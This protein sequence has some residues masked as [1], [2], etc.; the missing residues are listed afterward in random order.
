MLEDQ[1]QA[2]KWYMTTQYD[3]D[4]SEDDEDDEEED[5]DEAEV[6]GTNGG[7]NGH[8]TT[9]EVRINERLLPKLDVDVSLP[10]PTDLLAHLFP[11]PG[12]EIMGNLVLQQ[13]NLWMGNG[14]S[15]KSS[16]LHHDFHD[17]LY[18]LVSALRILS[19]TSGSNAE[20]ISLSK[21]SGRKRFLIWPPIAHRWLEPVGKVDV[22]HSNG[23]IEYDVPGQ[24]PLLADGLTRVESAKWL[25]R[26][27][28]RAL[29]EADEMAARMTGEQ[30]VE[31]GLRKGKGKQTAEQELAL[32]RLR[33]AEVDLYLLQMEGETGQEESEVL[34]TISSQDT[35]SELSDLFEQDEE[36]TDED[37]DTTDEKM[38]DSDDDLKLDG[39]DD[40]VDEFSS[41]EEDSKRTRRSK[42]GKQSREQESLDEDEYANAQPIKKHRRLSPKLI[43][44]KGHLPGGLR[45][46]LQ[47][48]QGDLDSGSDEYADEDEEGALVYIDASTEEDINGEEAA[49][50]TLQMRSEVVAR[51]RGMAGDTLTEEQSQGILDGQLPASNAVEEDLDSDTGDSWPDLDADALEEG[52]AAL[53]E[54]ARLQDKKEG[55]SRKTTQSKHVDDP[56][57]FSRIEPKVIQWFFNKPFDPQTNQPPMLPPSPE[58]KVYLAPREGCPLPMEIHLKAGQMLYLPASWYHEV[59]SYSDS[60]EESGLHMALN[61]W[62]HPP[63]AIRRPNQP[64]PVQT[65]GGSRAKEARPDSSQPYLNSEVWDEIRRCVNRKV[66]AIRRRAAARQQEAQSL[67]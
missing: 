13:C 57:S 3:D 39:K 38:R 19:T 32:L 64:V 49:I 45:G 63:T 62:F 66:D 41:D 36:F 20:P 33:E 29:L 53:E 12:P 37:E 10:A 60:Q 52:E 18:M 58:D 24:M 44:P 43:I 21:L 9:P 22:V 35:Y 30:H 17:N 40:E 4:G 5:G 11:L 25:F 48:L 28:L 15:G 23:L 51:M 34:S 55:A 6:N 14:K 7:H 1:E 2:G 27:R 42:E 61:Y 16:G 54:L 50:M 8:G 26:A 65:R 47:D 59:T 31:K 56:R 46:S 67:P